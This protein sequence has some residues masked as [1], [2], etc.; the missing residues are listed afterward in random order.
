MRIQC[1]SGS[2]ALHMLK[3]RREL[4]LLLLHALLPLQLLTQDFRLSHGLLVGG[5][6]GGREMRGTQAHVEDAAYAGP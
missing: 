3:T 5:V 4:G 1:C 6:R 2:G